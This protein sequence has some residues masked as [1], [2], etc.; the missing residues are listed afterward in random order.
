MSNIPNTFAA[1]SSRSLGAI[2]SRKLS[3]QMVQGL[4]TA[5]LKKPCQQFKRKASVDGGGAHA[6]TPG[7]FS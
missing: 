6:V 4:I 3:P 1:I 2:N 5:M 7:R